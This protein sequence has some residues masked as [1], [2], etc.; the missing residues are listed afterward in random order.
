MN[1]TYE[2]KRLGGPILL[3]LVTLL[4]ALLVG[5]SQANL[6]VILFKFLVFCPAL[7]L[8]HISRKSLFPYM[9]LSEAFE[10]HGYVNEHR[11]AAIIIA[12]I[13]YYVGMAYVLTAV[14]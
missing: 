3:G 12:A 13:I 9:D 6:E 1:L 2:L 5:I 8:I 14:I 11:D 4:I 7:V 10:R